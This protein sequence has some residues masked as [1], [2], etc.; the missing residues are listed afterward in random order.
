M[1]GYRFLVAMLRCCI[2]C[3]QFWMVTN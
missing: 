2:G 1:P 3:V